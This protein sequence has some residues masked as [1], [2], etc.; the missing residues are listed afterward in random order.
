MDVH[1]VFVLDFL[2]SQVSNWL[3]RSFLALILIGVDSHSDL[4]SQM[5]NVIAFH[6]GGGCDSAH[7][8]N[9]EYLINVI[10]VVNG[11]LIQRSSRP[12]EDNVVV[13]DFYGVA[14]NLCLF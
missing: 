7:A 1:K 14:L 5:G 2:S 13:V 8:T 9:G 12:I 4:A 3:L 11:D 10:E 6:D